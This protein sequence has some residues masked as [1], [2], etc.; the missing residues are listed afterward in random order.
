M[1]LQQLEYAVAIAREQHFARAAESCFVTQPT[2]SMMIQ[3]LEDELG[4]RL[5]DRSR[6]PVTV[7]R[8]GEV[9][10]ARARQI[11]ADVSRLRDAVAELR[12]SVTGDVRLGI[13]PTLAPYLLPML[14]PRLQARYPTLRLHVHEWQTE[15]LH[16]ALRDGSVDLA[17]LAT[18]VDEVAGLTAIPLF[19]EEFVAYVAPHEAAF[20]KAYILPEDL[21]L[22]RLW[23][24]EEGHCLRGQ[25]QHLCALRPQS[26]D[27]QQLVYEAGSLETLVNLVD[28]QG[29][30][31]V[32]PRLAVRFLDAGRRNRVRDFADPTPVREVQLAVAKSY[33]RM[34]VLHAVRDETLAA[35]ETAR[36]TDPAW[37]GPLHFTSNQP[38]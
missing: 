33:A 4:L 36:N 10:L 26:L 25:V 34:G 8:E 11:L 21:S 35:F 3:K 28:S 18:P 31:T 15:R 16:L 23:L 5:F 20:S 30:I 24:L 14:L 27:D 38:A 37:T 17:L 7:T 29:G 19:Q 32:L 1:T 2:L 9:V 13:I 22:T 12:G 6:Q